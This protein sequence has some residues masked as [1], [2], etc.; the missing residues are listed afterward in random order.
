[1]ATG[2][3]VATATA[4]DSAATGDT[5]AGS[6]PAPTPPVTPV[7]T[8]STSPASSVGA[9]AGVNAP[10][11]PAATPSASP[12]SSV[13]AAAPAVQAAPSATAQAAAAADPPASPAPAATAQAAAPAAPAVNA[14]SGDATG[15][16]GQVDTTDSNVQIGAV[17]AAGGAGGLTVANSHST[18]IG[19]ASAA[20]SSSGVA[21]AL[22]PTP[23]AGATLTGVTTA[24]SGAASA[25]GAAVAN[26]VR[27]TDAAAVLVQGANQAPVNVVSNANVAIQDTG[28]AGVTSGAAWAVAAGAAGAPSNV[29]TPVTTGAAPTSAAESA[30]GIQANNSL[31]NATSS[32][33][34]V[35]GGP[36]NTAPINVTPAQSVSNTT[37]GY[38]TT[39]SGAAC[40]GATCASPAGATASGATQASSGASQA[41]G[42]VAQNNVQTNA[43]VAVDVGGQNF[44]PITVVV[45]SITRI[46]NWGT[47]SATSGDAV[48]NGSSAG[49]STAS[50]VGA[51]SGSSEA[52]GAEVANSVALHSSAAVHVAGDNYSPINVLL[53]LAASIVNWGV[54][55]AT[56]G[57]A[58]STGSGG[59]AATSGAASATGLRAVNLVSLW[60][61]ASVDIDGNNYA[62][63]FIQ[64]LFNTNVANVGYAGA[65]T[66]NVATSSGATSNGST[67]QSTSGSSSVGSSSSGG[68]A[69]R[70]Q[71]GAAVA[72]SNSV[73]VAA[74]SNQMSNAN[75][76]GSVATTAV[77]EM[78]TNL[79]PG[80]W[81]P[82]VQQNLPDTAAPPVVAGMSSSSGNSVAVGLQSNIAAMN[83]QIAACRDPG[84]S[85]TAVNSNTTSISMSD[86]AHNPATNSSGAARG[87]GNQDGGG[88]D[89]GFG[90]G[91]TSSSSGFSGVNATPT[92]K[93]TSQTS[94]S[95][96]DDAAFDQGPDASSDDGGGGGNGGAGGAARRFFGAN[97]IVRGPGVN[98]QV[99][100][101]DLFD[102]W[103]GRR[104]P[105]M[106]NPLDSRV[107]SSTISATLAG[108]PGVDELPLPMPGA[109]DASG[110]APARAAVA[111]GSGLRRPLGPA[112]L[113]LQAADGDDLYP[114]LALVDVDLWSRWPQAEFMPMP[115][116]ALPAAAAA[117]DASPAVV[118]PDAATPL[119]PDNG[120]LPMQ[121]DLAALL[122]MLTI[123]LRVAMRHGQSLLA[124]VRS[125]FNQ[126]RRAQILLRLASG[127]LRLW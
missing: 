108:F 15:L 109:A 48:A 8:P 66:G 85:C 12:A 72:I 59:G 101:V 112:S 104:L 31:S 1:M 61:D 30:T 41:Q 91:G 55:T 7:A 33:V 70:A 38:A 10:D 119:P 102:Q 88:S 107:S 116:Q 98:G 45:N 83:G 62:P 87:S 40:A 51:A 43:N 90:P 106:P 27:N 26:D 35:A 39:I 2:S 77:A 115:M 125:W 56:S 13:G 75:G 65:S 74:V 19:D 20:S 22:A 84:V 29:S 103:P 99:V 32:T 117:V 11:V 76:G 28:A 94:N 21:V 67:P 95:G 17:A 113:D 73:N 79:P 69:S 6:D 111:S 92:P 93:T 36:G 24:Q 25:V 110:P 47:A 81:N 78:L 34:N 120:A 121:L 53:N 118:V 122:S 49:G 44:A 80:P 42:V 100:L 4:G 23:D 5:N 124:V 18:T 16:A 64:V 97:A 105:P 127:M 123:T 9:A 37:G 68:A 3:A 82:F 57:D 86:L 58:Q 46:F 96:G 50:A 126:R 71:G 114:P 89:P 60:A 14:G 52:T 63:I 54:A